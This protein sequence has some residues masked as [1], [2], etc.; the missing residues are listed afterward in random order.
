[1]VRGWC[2]A[3]FPWQLCWSGAPLGAHRTGCC[4]PQ[5]RAVLSQG[6]RGA[7][8]CWVPRAPRRVAG[9]VWPVQGGGRVVDLSA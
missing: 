3:S 1:M 4:S 8:G 9:A 5:V 6:P 2:R 7:A